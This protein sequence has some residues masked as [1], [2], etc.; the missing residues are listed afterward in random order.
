MKSG[1]DKTLN[2]KYCDVVLSVCY[3]AEKKNFIIASRN[4]SR[5]CISNENAYSRL[6]LELNAFLVFI[7]SSDST[8]KLLW[9]LIYT[10]LDGANGKIYIFQIVYIL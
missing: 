5:C 9:S 6:S 10:G 4:A 7:P 3:V 8:R 2:K 1:C